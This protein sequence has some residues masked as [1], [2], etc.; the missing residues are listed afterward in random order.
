MPR[1]RR[2]APG[3]GGGPPAKKAKTHRSDKVPKTQCSGLTAQLTRCTREKHT[4]GAP[5]LCFQ[6][7]DDLGK[8][9]DEEMDIGDLSRS[10]SEIRRPTQVPWILPRTRSSKQRQVIFRKY[11]S[12][13][14]QR[15]L[16][17]GDFP[18]ESQL[19]RAPVYSPLFNAS[20]S[21]R[22]SRVDHRKQAQVAH[23][24]SQSSTILKTFC[25]D[26][27][28]I[29]ETETAAGRARDFFED[30]A[31]NTEALVASFDQTFDR[32]VYLPLTADL[33]VRT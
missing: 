18:L 21:G 7:E 25:Q 5:Y 4:G 22:A 1:K 14:F 29:V 20:Q 11:F 15:D 10:N 32:V 33:I 24:N 6:H 13:L 28:N 27:E 8:A 16:E 23:E 17:D 12:P 19:Q 31:N 30:V 2:G 9:V 3:G 26:I